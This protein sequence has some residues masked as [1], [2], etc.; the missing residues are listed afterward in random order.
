MFSGC[1]FSVLSLF[2]FILSL[3]EF[4]FWCR[5]AVATATET[6]CEHACIF[7]FNTSKTEC[8]RLCQ[9]LTF[10]NSWSCKA[11][12]FMVACS[13]HWEDQ[14][15]DCRCTPSRISRPNPWSTWQHAT[16]LT[17]RSPS[18]SMISPSAIGVPDTANISERLSPP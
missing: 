2:E 3:I 5:P 12:Y 14:R 7:Q 8:S 11:K 16:T 4:N 1:F 15:P 10:F 6:E 13:D 9:I 17:M 18:A